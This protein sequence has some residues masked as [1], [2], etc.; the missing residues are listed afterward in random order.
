MTTA[1][2]P[3][4]TTESSALHE[5]VTSS[6]GNPQQL[7]KNLEEFLVRF[8][9]A[10]QRDQVLNT[11]FQQ[12]LRT[13]DPSTA[14]TYGEKLLDAKPSDN[15]AVN[16][17]ST[18][19]D[20]LDRQG[21]KA[22]RDKALGYANQLVTR[23]D[24]TGSETRPERVSEDQ[25]LQSQALARAAAY[26]LRARLY[27]ASKQPDQAQADYLKSFAAYPTSRVAERLGDLEAE[28]GRTDRAL[29]HYA[30]SFAL[31]ESDADPQ[32]L[33]DL[34]RKLGSAYVAE[35][36]SEKGLGDLVLARYDELMRSLRSR[37]DKRTHAHADIHDPFA[38]ALLRPD[39]SEVR[40]SDFRGKV[41]VMD[42]WATWCG[43]CIMEGYLLEQAVER[44]R[45]E[46]AAVFLAV[47]VDEDRSH[48][49]DFARSQQWTIPVVYAQGLDVSLEVHALPT[50][51]IL[52]REGR[53]V[54]RQEGASTDVEGL[55]RR[56]RQTLEAHTAAA[57]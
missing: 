33:D 10:R 8:P 29:D 45:A 32:H 51:M 44:L 43:P 27:I 11:I 37:F 36:G 2:K 1:P 31:R 19:L 35:H 42:F 18:I 56:V 26:S 7:I 57:R 38:S 53:V 55:E 47:N 6:A 16:I 22:S 28:A 39:G 50:L 4:A 24:Q 15:E 13:N 20:L 17:L 34:R 40:L 3:V 49:M 46:P 54:Y 41:V 12:A 48:V 9:E 30:S 23:A 14:I 5:A 52:D 25:W 21:D